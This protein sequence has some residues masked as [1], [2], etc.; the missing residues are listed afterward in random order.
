MYLFHYTATFSRRN[1]QGGQLK[2][3]AQWL[4][5]LEKYNIIIPVHNDFGQYASDLKNF[6]SKKFAFQMEHPARSI[7]AN[8][9]EI[10]LHG[11][12]NIAI[13]AWHREVY[14]VMVF[15]C[16]L[17]WAQ[18]SGRFRQQKNT[19]V[20]LLPKNTIFWWKT[21]ERCRYIIHRFDLLRRPSAVFLADVADS[22]RKFGIDKR[23][24]V[25]WVRRW[26]NWVWWMLQQLN[27]EVFSN[28]RCALTTASKHDE[29][30]I[31]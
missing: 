4:Y 16:K 29:V 26:V 5:H 21:P 20:R 23:S 28:I 22:H 19:V 2:Y 6:G 31:S 1:Q 17:S 8:R 3:C 12:N 9:V 15:R 10:S 14:K 30:W 27:D 24:I 18:R 25:L 7:N 11:V 13:N